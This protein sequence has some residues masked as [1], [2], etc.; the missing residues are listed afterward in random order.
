MA[1]VRTA[2]PVHLIAGRAEVAQV[3]QRLHFELL[4]RLLAHELLAVAIAVHLDQLRF[5]EI[6][7]LAL[8]EHVV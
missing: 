4:V 8:D 7:A 5:E 1:E 3:L 2:W 6:A